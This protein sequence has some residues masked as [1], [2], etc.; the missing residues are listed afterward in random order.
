MVHL[1]D[2]PRA[3]ATCLETF[4]KSCAGY[5]VITYILGIGDRHLDNLLLRNDG[6]LFHVDFGFI[7]GRHPKPFPPPMKLCKEMVEAMG[8]A[9]SN[10]ILNIFHL[11]AG[12]NTPDITSDPEKGILK[13]QE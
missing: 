5:S 10:L 2:S 6:R 12:S 8:G 13:L 3:Q 11:M 1:S 7:L 9:E 4:I